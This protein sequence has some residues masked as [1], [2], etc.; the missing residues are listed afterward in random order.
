[1]Q[2]WALPPTATKLLPL[3]T[4]QWT[5]FCRMPF[6]W[7]GFWLPQINKALIYRK[8]NPQEIIVAE[9]ASHYRNCMVLFLVVFGS[10]NSKSYFS[11]LLCLRFWFFE[12]ACLLSKYFFDSVLIF[13]IWRFGFAIAGNEFS[14]ECPVSCLSC[15]IALMSWVF[16]IM[17]IL[18]GTLFFCCVLSYF[19]LLRLPLFLFLFF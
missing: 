3:G 8:I 9:I 5:A 14:V 11:A 17:A 15:M 10:Y 7:I 13:P 6:S 2:G 19:V 4:I 18:E 16:I 12:L 1:M